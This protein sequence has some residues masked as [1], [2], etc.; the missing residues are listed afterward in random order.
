TVTTSHPILDM[1]QTL[2]AGGVAFTSLKHNVTITAADLTNSKLIDFR[3]GGA[4]YFYA[5]SDGNIV[6]DM[7]T[8]TTFT[9]PLSV[10]YQ[11]SSLF[12]VNVGGNCSIGPVNGILSFFNFGGQIQFGGVVGLGQTG[13]AG[14]L[15]FTDGQGNN[16]NGWFNFAGQTR[17]GS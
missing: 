11:G 9:L 16:I 6:I 7:Q 15:R 10:K 1:T 17:V 14:P 3:L 5:Q 2:N 8:C 4:S 13:S 12:N